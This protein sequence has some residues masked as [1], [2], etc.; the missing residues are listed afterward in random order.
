MDLRA[1]GSNEDYVCLI[2]SADEATLRLATA[3]LKGHDVSLRNISSLDDVHEIEG[4]VLGLM[5]GHASEDPIRMAQY[6]YTIEKDAPVVILTEPR[7]TKAILKTAQYT[8]YIGMNVVVLDR[9]DKANALARIHKTFLNAIQAKKHKK[10]ISKSNFLI[11]SFQSSVKKINQHFVEKLVDNLPVG[12]AVVKL[13]GSVLEMNRKAMAIFSLEDKEVLGESIFTFFNPEQAGLL[14]RYLPERASRDREINVQPL[15]LERTAKNDEKQTLSVIAAPF[16]SE[17]DKKPQLVLS[18]EDITQTMRLVEELREEVQT[19][20][21]FLSIASHELRTPLTAMRLNLEFLEE[22]TKSMGD[23]KI[24][25]SELISGSIK[26]VDRLGLLVE[27]LLDVSRIQSGKLSLRF[28]KVDLSELLRGAL[29]LLQREIE[30]AGCSLSINIEPEVV[31]CWD[32]NRLEQVINNLMSNAL[33]YAPKTELHISLSRDGKHAKL[34]VEDRGPGMSE[35]EQEKIYER[36]ERATT[37]R[38]VSGLGLGLFIAKKIV[39][40]HAGKITLESARGKGAKFTVKL[41]LS[42]D[43][44][45][46]GGSAGLAWGS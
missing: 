16:S 32:R 3:G 41:P 13:D 33:K 37:S 26:Q 10:A 31:G 19:R 12:V 4:V 34:S 35:K 22:E 6:F 45:K 17:G 29:T 27:D 30:R 2:H 36:F 5:I 42:L 24:F 7:E 15:V 14:R 8:P 18:I 21:N 38:S 43:T 46:R 11:P 39:E 28:E 23:S 40:G 20:D 1:S 9:Y 44:K 25:F